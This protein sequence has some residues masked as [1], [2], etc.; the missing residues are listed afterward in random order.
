MRH[1]VDITTVEVME[2]LTAHHPDWMI[3]MADKRQ[4][5]RVMGMPE[6]EA[7]EW[8]VNDHARIV[9]RIHSAVYR[10]MMHQSK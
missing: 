8:L 10:T 4:L 2:T 1:I 9:A 3:E 7:R 5:V 6:S